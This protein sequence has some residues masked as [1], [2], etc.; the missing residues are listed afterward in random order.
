VPSADLYIE[1]I[2]FLRY[3]N[4]SDCRKCGFPSCAEF[5]LALGAEE[6]DV[7]SCPFLSR[8][9]SYAFEAVRKIQELWPAVPLL[10]HPRPGFT[11]LIELNN[12]DASSLVLITGNNEYTEQVV[13][14]VLGTTICPFFVIFADSG[15]NTVDM[16]MVYGTFTAESIH[17]SLCETGIGEKVRTRELMIPGLA[18]PLQADIEKLSGWKVNAGP[19]CVAELP[20]C[21]SE[22]WIPPEEQ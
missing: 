17:R 4:Q 21:L 5:F 12:P 8:N 20:L 10:T 15:G 19:V 18:R 16:A 9:K 22:I 13:M 14:T 7:H 2:D 6:A 1:K 11:G 3:L